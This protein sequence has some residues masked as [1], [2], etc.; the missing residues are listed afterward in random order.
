MPKREVVLRVAWVGIEGGI[1]IYSSCLTLGSLMMTLN[2]GTPIE[3]ML[4]F[5]WQFFGSSLL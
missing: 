2:R 1:C 4:T 5:I 3:I